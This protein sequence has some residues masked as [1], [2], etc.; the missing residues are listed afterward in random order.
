MALTAN[1]R[2][3]D[4]QIEAETKARVEHI[5]SLVRKGH[6]IKGVLAEMDSALGYEERLALKKYIHA[7]P[8]H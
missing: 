1:E 7:H 4:E 3:F 8:F 2:V 6:S 5:Y